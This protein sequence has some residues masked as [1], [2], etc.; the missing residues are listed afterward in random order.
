MLR[1][2]EEGFTLIE[3]LVVIAIIGV[4]ASIVI[5]SLNTAREKGNK[6]AIKGNLASIQTQSALYYDDNLMSYGKS[7]IAAV[8]VC[9]VT[10]VIDSVFADPTVAA[11]IDSAESAGGLAGAAW[12]ALGGSVAVGTDNS[13]SWAVSVAYKDGTGSWC[14]DSTGY[15]GGSATAKAS[16]G[17]VAP[18][19][20][21]R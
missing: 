4:L 10:V 8:A 3:L 21:I 13:Q 20:C 18:A 17:G 16:G 2:K 1:K 14:T 12:C 11:A 9:N 5:A 6:A 7:A 15:A 19:V